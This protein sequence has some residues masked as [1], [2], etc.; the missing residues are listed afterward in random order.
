MKNKQLAVKLKYSILQ[1]KPYLHTLVMN[2]PFTEFLRQKVI[3]FTRGD[4]DKV[5]YDIN[6][7][8]SQFYIL[9]YKDTL[10]DIYGQ[11]IVE[12]IIPYIMLSPREEC[13]TQLRIFLNHICVQQKSKIYVQCSLLNFG[14]AGQLSGR[15]LAQVSAT[16]SCCEGEL[17]TYIQLLL[18]ILASCY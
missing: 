14:V 13:S 15:V 2:N 4:L 7:I 10:I 6:F 9:Q 5:C 1:C 18:L 16:A 17:F 11:Y 3:A 8:C 12:Q